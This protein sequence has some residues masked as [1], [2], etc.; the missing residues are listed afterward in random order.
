MRSADTAAPWP[1]SRLSRL[2]LALPF[3][4]VVVRVM[5]SDFDSAGSQGECDQPPSD[6]NGYYQGQCHRPFPK[7]RYYETTNSP[8]VSQITVRQALQAGPYA[9]GCRQPETTPA[10]L[11]QP[12]SLTGS[13][14]ASPPS[15]RLTCRRPEVRA[16]RLTRRTAAPRNES[17]PLP[18]RPCREPWLRGSSLRP[19]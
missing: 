6:E 3:L 19:R 14:N 18:L 7:V 17:R 1:K 10:P 15:R 12:P 2:M 11:V 4:M 13:H 8:A 16:V 5:P 9:R